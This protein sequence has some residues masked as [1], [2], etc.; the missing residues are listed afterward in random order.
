VTFSSP[1][2]LQNCVTASQACHTCHVEY[3]YKTGVFYKTFHHLFE[4]YTADRRTDTRCYTSKWE[5]RT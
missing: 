1:F 3:F 4:A 2:W 5:D